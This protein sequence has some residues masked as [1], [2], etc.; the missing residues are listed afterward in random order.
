VTAYDPY[1]PPKLGASLQL[2]L[3]PAGYVRS[4]T[5]DPR[6]LAR[7]ASPTDSQ[8]LPAKTSFVQAI[9]VYDAANGSVRQALERYAKGRYDPVG[10]YAAREYRVSMDRY[11]GFVYSSLIDQIIHSARLRPVG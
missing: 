8:S 7:Q 9:G 11:C 10:P 4:A 5:V 6:L 3:K 1:E 2:F